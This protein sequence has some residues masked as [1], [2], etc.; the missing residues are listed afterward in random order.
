MIKTRHKF[1]GID[2]PEAIIE[3]DRVTIVREP[4]APSG[5]TVIAFYS[6][7]ANQ[8]AKDNGEKPLEQRK[9]IFDD[10]RDIKR[11]ADSVTLDNIRDNSKKQFKQSGDIFLAV[12]HGL[13]KLDKFKDA[14]IF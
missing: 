3:L 13:K 4:Q 8:D 6:V 9:C 7:Y 12:E 2:I 10:P 11:H 1:A 5:I 14:V